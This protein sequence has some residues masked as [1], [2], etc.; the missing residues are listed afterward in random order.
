M[1]TRVAAVLSLTCLGLALV[2]TAQTPASPRDQLVVS[3]A[4]LAQHLDDSDVV[5]LQ[6]GERKT[7]DAGHVPGARFVAL[8]D[9]SVSD[10]SGQGLVLEM[11]PADVL[12]DRLAALGVS[13]G[14]RV[15][16]V[17]SDDWWS[18]AARVLFTLD[19]AGLARAAWLDGGLTAWKSAGHPTS[20][21]LPT[22]KAGTLSPLKVKPIV[23][24]AEF[25]RAHQGKPGFALVDARAAEFYDGS[26]PG[27]QRGGPQ[28]SGH[29]P[30]ALSA[31]YSLFVGDAVVLRS[32]ADVGAAFEKAGVKPGDTVIGYCH[33]GQQATA[34]LLAARTLGHPVLLY[35]GSFQDWATRDLAVENPAARK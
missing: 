34:M 27:G 25:V 17:E 8:S 24:D 28:K 3:P 7:Y 15:V 31:P 14:S 21:D 6:V 35:D 26:K 9:L 10:T 16:V 1:R 22:I 4:W 33:I 5:V 32:A 12:H 19:Y 30:G 29:I 18:P 23:V 20:T 2:T 11:L 13:D